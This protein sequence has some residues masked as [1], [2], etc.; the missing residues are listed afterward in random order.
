MPYLIRYATNAICWSQAPERLG[1]LCK[2]RKRWHRG[3]Y[4]CMKIHKRMLG[5]KRFAAISYISYPY[6]LI[7]ELYS[8]YIEVFGIISMIVAY[9]VDLL[10]VPYMLLFFGIYAIFGSIMTLTAFFSR[11]QTIDLSISFSDVIKV[12]GLCFFEITFLRFI[13]ATVR[14]RALLGMHSKKQMT[15]GSIQR[16]KLDFKEK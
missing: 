11:I 9:F 3:L 10:N 5:D 8:P 16:K 7:Y 14:M 2:Q 15:W 12:I 13:M 6:F 4:Q 1:D